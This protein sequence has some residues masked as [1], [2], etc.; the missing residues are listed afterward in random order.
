[1]EFLIRAR[2]TG[3]LALLCTVTAVAAGQPAAAPP[4]PVTLAVP[5]RA[6]AHV[7]VAAD[8]A[9]VVAV[10]AASLP[11]GATDIYA[12]ASR[13]GGVTFSFP[14]RVNATA[15]EARVNGEQPPR[16]AL[17]PGAGSQPV[18]TVV[19]TAKGTLGTKL[20]TARSLDGGRTFAKSVIVA[21]TDSPG[22][23]GWEAIA[24]GRRGNV[25][26]LWLDHRRLAP[27]AGQPSAPGAAHHNHAASAGGRHDGVAMAQLSQLYIGTVDDA[28]T[29]RAITGG[30]CYCCKT[31]LVTAPDGTLNAAWRHVYPGNLR[32][33]AFASSQ[34]SGR[35]FSAPLRVSEDNW[36][37]DGC[38]D[39]GPAMAVDD[40][41]RVHLIWPTRVLDDR[42][43]PTVGL[44]YAS[45]DGGQFSQ[46]L[47]L[48]TDGVP[49][50]PQVAVASDVLLAAWDELRN[51]TRQVVLARASLR[52]PHNGFSR[53][54]V[55]GSARGIYP[56]MV[57]TAEGAVVAWTARTG[58][59]A[60]VRV[61]RI[62]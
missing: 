51:G 58:A 30:V 25:H 27:D 50:H 47:R 62:P 19:W 5:G 55:S 24:A 8:G 53:W 28:A 54:I 14:A 21:G 31:A 1:M 12:A 17:T 7:S 41:N 2:R 43:R 35:T 57:V 18:I 36:Q 13:D 52:E 45:R 60:T 61:M 20:M 6:S 49:H 22:N 10:W 9:F 44:F 3:G 37:L 34:D 48:P 38:P 39:D 42:Q 16:V 56:S 4:T 32:D 46:R 59:S 15:G 11:D 26:L 40:D 23:R 33:I 29:F